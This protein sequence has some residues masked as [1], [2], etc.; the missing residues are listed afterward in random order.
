M[1]AGLSAFSFALALSESACH[2]PT[3]QN[4]TDLPK[5]ALEGHERADLPIEKILID[6]AFNIDPRRSSD[7]EL[8]E[9]MAENIRAHGLLEPLVV[10]AVLDRAKGEWT[11]FLL[12]GF[13]RHAAL[14]RLGYKVA[15]VVIKRDIDELGALAINGA[16]NTAR[17]QVHP[18]YIAKRF[19]FLH[20]KHGLPF[21]EI[22]RLHGYSEAYVSNLVVT[23]QRTNEDI[24]SKVF[25]TAD[26][27]E[28][29]IPTIAWLMSNAKKTPTEQQEAY[30]IKYGKG[31]DDARLDAAD[32]G[33][34]EIADNKPK[35]PYLRN[36]DEMLRLLQVQLHP[37]FSL[38]VALKGFEGEPKLS[39]R[40]RVLC[41]AVLMWVLDRRKPFPFREPKK[42]KANKSL[43][44]ESE[45]A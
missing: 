4:I 20:V 7:E 35:R 11:F 44:E 13:V 15:P 43:T 39:K 3:V 45:S 14:K 19:E 6:P 34:L 1:G 17:R 21:K 18:F 37:D 30:E 29:R 36:R 38:E 9:R 8:V 42:G 26:V 24:R 2:A 10:H 32:H 41:K 25:E 22:A 16:E 33:A 23:Y 31:R 12:A 27:S 5:E 40:E 28:E